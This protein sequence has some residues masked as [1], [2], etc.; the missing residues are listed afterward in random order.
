MLKHKILVFK[1]KKLNLE[2]DDLHWQIIIINKIQEYWQSV[3]IS[4]K[5][6]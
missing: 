6:Y 5:Y 1:R 3:T 4:L 2:K